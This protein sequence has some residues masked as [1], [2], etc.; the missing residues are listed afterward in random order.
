MDWRG[1]T[2]LFPVARD[3]ADIIGK[4]LEEHHPREVFVGF[5]GGDDSLIAAHWMMN[6]VPG[7]KVLHINTGIGIERTREFV[8]D[9]C[10][11]YGWLLVEIRA[12][13]DCG[14]DYDEIVK[15]W[16]FPGPSSHRLMYIRLKER[17]VEKLVRDHKQKRSDR[18]LIATGIYK[19]ESRR[20]AG[21]GSRVINRNGAQVWVNPFY[22]W[23][24]DQFREYRQ[25]NAILT[26]PVSQVLGMSGECL[27][28][29]FAHKGEKALIKLVCPE[30]HARIERLEREVRACGFEWG[31]EGHPPHGGVLNTTPPGLLC[32]GC[33]K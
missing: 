12:K 19:E 15:R 10:A 4:A 11:V 8:R 28:G 24:P 18:I 7:C 14:Q 30:T 26:N 6:N 1:Q 23:T 13:E 32:M 17:C 25:Q 9:T 29:A 16:G 27:C 33:E 3:P 2:E 20:R 22:Y 31:W 5:S 21:Y